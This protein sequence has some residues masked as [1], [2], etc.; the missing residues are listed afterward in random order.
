MTVKVYDID[1]AQTVEQVLE[2][3]IMPRYLVSKVD[4]DVIVALL[5]EVQNDAG[6]WLASD[7]QR[8]IALAVGPGGTSPAGYP[9][10]TGAE[11]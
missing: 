11:S 1:A 8:R 9:D 3:L 4:Y 6:N 7:L 10:D 5:R 2:P